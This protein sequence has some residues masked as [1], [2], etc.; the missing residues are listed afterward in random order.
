[1][2][3][4]LARKDVP[5][6]LLVGVRI[7]VTHVVGRNLGGMTGLSSRNILLI[8]C[9]TI[10]GF[11][12][13]QLASCG[14]GTQGGTLSLV[15][16]DVLGTGNLGRHVLG[17]ADLGRNKAEAVA[18][19]LRRH[20]PCID[21]DPKAARIHDLDVSWTRHQ[22]VIDATGEEALSLALNEKAVRRR[23]NHPDHLFIWLTGN[24][25]AAQGLLTG[26]PSYACLKCLKPR[27]AGPP[28]FRTLRPNVPIETVSAFACGDATHVPFPVSRSVVAASMA[29]EMALEWASERRSRRFRTLTL[30]PDKAFHVA[31]SSPS[32]LPACP[33]CGV[34]R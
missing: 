10:G 24:G 8:G 26:E 5:I 4:A 34:G 29:C 9:G 13:H 31:D 19:L 28:R 30:D 32:A 7:D 25:A 16:P 21:V 23:P 1:M 22:L 11:L 17:V 2:L 3:Q 18:D 14:A 33:A 12:A 27:L 6:E 15:D 20:L